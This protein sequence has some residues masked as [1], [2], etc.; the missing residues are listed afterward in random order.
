MSSDVWPS[1][2]NSESDDDFSDL[3]TAKKTLTAEL[4]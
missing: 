4:D 2:V 3:K 1:G